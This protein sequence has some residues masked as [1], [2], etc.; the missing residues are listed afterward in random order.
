MRVLFSTCIA[1]ATFI[2]PAAAQQELPTFDPTLEAGGWVAATLATSGTARA[3]TACDDFNRPDGPVG[4]DWG[5]IS[6]A[7]GIVSQQ[8][9]SASNG[10][11]WMLHNSAKSN[12]QDAVVEFDLVPGRPGLSYSAA[13][14]G[15]NPLTGED[16]YI[17]VQG[18]GGVYGNYGFYHGFNGGAYNGWGGF[19]SLPVAI[20][21]GRVSV[22]LT[23]NGD[24]AN[25]DIDENYDGIVDHHFEA[26]GVVTSGLAALLG[27]GTGYGTYGDGAGDNWS[28]NGCAPT[29][30]LLTATGLIAGQL[31]TWEVTQATPGRNVYFAYSLAGG[32]P[33]T[34]GAG[35]CG[36]LTVELNRPATILPPVLVDANGTASVSG[37]VPGG[38][39][40]VNIWIQA[41][42]VGSCIV[43]NGLAEVIG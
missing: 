38:T 21:E 43:S 9:H 34:F 26:A 23:N 5:I 20:A 4:G 8:I 10:N 27:D 17:K 42:D 11:S 2:Q 36:T 22:Y 19:F 39:S 31:T 7:L 29:G 12:Y 6:G 16:L 1:L 37:L 28:L 32:G 41:L 3:N 15:Y 30:P 33:V 35:P 18:S 40:G 24:T 14:I 13:V 25:L